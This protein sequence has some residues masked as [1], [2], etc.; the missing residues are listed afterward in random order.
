[1]SCETKISKGFQIVVPLE[2]RKEFNL[3]PGD[4]LEWI[5]NKNEIFVKVRK[6]KHFKD[7]IGIISVDANAVELKKKAQK[8][9]I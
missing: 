3:N 8:G 7:I 6:R 1:M 2:I 5:K 4:K 9:E